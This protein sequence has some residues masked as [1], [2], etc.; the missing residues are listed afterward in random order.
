MTHTDYFLLL[1]V[2]WGKVFAI[3]RWE[4]KLTLSFLHA[5]QE[6]SLIGLARDKV[7]EE[8]REKEKAEAAEAARLEPPQ[9]EMPKPYVPGKW[10]RVTV[11]GINVYPDLL[12][13]DDPEMKM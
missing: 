10:T 4:D 2:A 5:P 12:D 8:R 3:D 11:Q 9:P 6:V 1:Q 7:V 13:T